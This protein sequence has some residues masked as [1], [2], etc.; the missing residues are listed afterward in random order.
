MTEPPKRGRGWVISFLVSLALNIALAWLLVKTND[1]RVFAWKEHEQLRHAVARLIE[2]FP[3]QFYS[4]NELALHLV[5]PA[6]LPVVSDCMVQDRNLVFFFD[7]NNTLT[8]IST[9]GRHDDDARYSCSAPTKERWNSPW[10][11]SMKTYAENACREMRAALAKDD[12]IWGMSPRDPDAKAASW[13]CPANAAQPG[14]PADVGRRGN[15][16]D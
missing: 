12:A 1:D 4:R 14:A 16:N 13:I 8:G 15:A 7:R 11:T 2:L 10:H 6:G 3:T 9:S 5:A